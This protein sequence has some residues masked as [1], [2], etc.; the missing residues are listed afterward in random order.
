MNIYNMKIEQFQVNTKF[1]NSLPPELSKF[2]IDVKLV[3]DLHTTNFDQLCAYLEQHE[4]HANEVRLLRERNQDPLAFI[5][6]QQMTPPHFN[7]YQDDPIACLNKAMDFL[8]V[9]ASSRFPSTNNQLRT[10]SN[11]RNHATIQDD[12]DEEQLELLADPGVPDGQAVQTIIPNNVAF[13][14]EDLDTYDSDCDDISNAK[15][16]LIDNISNYGS[17]VISEEKI[18]LKEQVDSL[19]KNLLKQIKEKECLLQTLTAFKSESKEKEDK[20]MENKIDFKKKIKEL[21]NVLF[22]VGQ[23]AQ[24]VHV[25]TKPQ[26]FYDN[27]HKQALGYQN[28]FHLK[29]AQ[30]IKP[31][32]YDGI[33]MSDKHI[34]M[35]VIDDEETLI[36]EEEKNEDLKVQIQDKVFVITSL[37]NDLR[38]IKGKEIADIGA[39]KPSANTIVP[40]MFKLDLEP[41]APCLL[42]NK[43]AHIDYLKL[44]DYQLGNVT[45]SRVY[46][47]EGLGHNLFSIGQFCNADLV[48]AFQKNTCFI[49]NL[50]GVDLIF[51][52]YDINL[53]TIS[54]DD[55]LKTSSICILSKASKTKSW[56]WHHRLSHLN[57]GTLNK[58]AKDGLARGIPRLKFLKD[59]LCS[60]CVLGKSKKSSHQPKAEHI[61]QEKLYLLYMDLCGPMRVASINGKRISHQTSVARTPQQN[62]VV[63]RQNRT[64]VEAAHTI[65]DWDHLFQPM[66]D[67]YFTPPSIVVSP[68]LVVA[69]PRA[70]DLADSLVSTLIDQDAPSASIPSIQKQEHSLRISQ[71]FKETPKTPTFHNDPLNESLHEDSTS[72]GSSLNVLQIQTLFKHLG[73]WIKDH[74][75]AN[76]IGDPSRSVST[77]KQLKTD[78]ILEVWELVQC[79]DKVML[80]KLKWIYKLKTDEFG[81]VLKNKARLVAQ[82]FRQEEGIDFEESFAPVARIEAICIF[83]AN[84]AH[85][86]M[87]SFQ[88]D[89]KTTFLNGEL[90]EEVYVS[91]PEGYVDQDNPSHVDSVD[92]PMVEKSKL[93]EDLQGKPVDTKLYCGMIGSLMY[94]TSSRPD[95]IYAVCLCARYQA[96]PIEK[97]LNAVKRIF[98]YL[99]GTIKMGLWYSKDTS[100]SLTAYADVDHAGCQDTR[101]STSGSAQF[102]SDKLLT[103]YGFQFNKIPLYCDNKSAIAL[104]CNN[105][106]HL[107][108][109]HID[110]RYHFIKEQVKNG[111]VELYFVRTEY[112]LA[113][114][115]TKPLPREKF[116][117]LIEKLEEDVLSFIKELGYSG[118]CEMLSTIRTDQMHQPWRT[119]D[120]AMYNQMNVDYVALLWEDFMYQA[121]N[122]KISSAR[123]EHMP[124]PRFTKVIINHFIFKDNTISMRNRI[125]LYTVR[126][127]TLLAYKTYI[128]YATRKVPPKKA[129]NFKK[130]AS[131]KLKTVP[132]SPKEPTQK[133]TLDKSVSKKKTPAKADSGKGIELLSDA[134]L[135]EDAQLKKTLR[136]SKRETHKL[137]RLSEDERDDVHEED[138]N[139][140]DDGNDDDSGNDD[141]GGNDAQDSERTNSDDDENPSFTLKDYQEEEQDEEYVHTPEKENL[142]MNKICMKKKTMM[143]QRSY[144]QNASHESGFVH[145]EE[146]AHVTLT[147]V[148][149][150]TEGPLQSF[151]VSSDFISKLLNLD[152]PSPD[153]NS[154]MNT[155]TVPPPPSLVNPSPRLT[156]I[157]QQQTPDFTTTTINPTMSL[158]EI[159]NFASL[160]QFDQRVSTLETKVF[161]FNQTSQ[162][163][164]A[165][166]LILGIVDNYLAFKLKEEVNMAVQLQS[167]KLREEDQAENQEFLNQVD[168]TMKAI[169][170]EQV[171]A[172]VSKIIPHIEKNLYNALVESYNTDKHILSSYGDV[173]T[174]KRGR[175]DQDKDIDPSAGLEWGTKRRKSKEPEFEAANTEMQQDQGNES[176]HIDDQPNNEAAPKHDW[177]KKPD[178]P[179]TPDRVW[180]KSKSVDFR[181]PQKWIST[182]AKARQPPRMFDELIGT[183]IDFSAYV[184][185]RLKIDNLT[186]EI[187]V[188]R[189]FNLLKGTCKSFT[190][191]EYH[192]EECYKAV[193]NKLDWNNTKGHAYPFNL[194]KPLPLTED[195]G[196]QV[197]T[198]NYFINN[199]LEYLKEG[200]SSSKYTTST[201]RT[202][203][204]KYDNI[205]GTY[206]WGPKRQRFYAYACHWKSPHDVY[207]KR[208]IIAVTSVKV[209]RW[210]DYR[211]LE[212]IVVQRDDNVRYKFKEGD[213]PRL[214]LCDIEDVL[215][216]LVQKKLS[217]L[218]IDDRYDLGVALRMFTRRII[219]LHRVEDLQIGVESYQKKLNITRP[220][221]FRSDIPNMISYTAYKNPQGIIYQDKF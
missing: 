194:S 151:S 41:L 59:H 56:L 147:T 12:K 137:K 52:S 5:A 206:H 65:D 6:N 171:K 55:M 143:S 207:S 195:Q 193:N 142:R 64:L 95:L 23:S 74:L 38:R 39:Q 71:C 121:D 37:K 67:E 177:F 43:E 184:M 29:K 104:C 178:K 192:F 45:I 140:D 220:E 108:A 35:P 110:V 57:F 22:K 91:Q 146:D 68:V 13:Q 33:V 130:L 120:A 219:I 216:I 54:L 82:G 1:L 166:S 93:D 16:V 60:A 109:K 70:V 113:D 31:T 149:D 78:A 122:K 75:I 199:D 97:H 50:E 118:S 139:D 11:P 136:K 191:L 161:E 132:L 32:L 18:A 145:E 204:A 92:T 176:G 83:V 153:I 21:D 119:F 8:T 157:P 175:D 62:G 148:H 209:M 169:I 180:N 173:V 44:C 94:L 134:A 150:K 197:E 186:Q 105:D 73:R 96:K 164:K 114:I 51:G 25:L 24:M 20:Y 165:V 131:P 90:K 168:S 112:Q 205:E 190:E 53:Y 189:G 208:R 81:E 211:Y 98:L 187:L 127:D 172:Q 174:L 202:K 198:A 48:V 84:A 201:T 27:I 181:P 103:D 160:F 156:T 88:I 155:S 133:D 179:L 47:V 49:R 152:D 167:N 123:K 221:T 159:P 213:F 141:S 87:T 69:A 76:M 3:K 158:P 126:D 14:T 215:L 101:R 124:Y 107:R 182:I 183:T 111:I 117:F 46:Y 30:R 80:I 86:N 217:S 102:L 115:F 7:T 163:A 185:N 85:K 154:L 26:A 99:K 36:L 89:V 203:D 100:M 214:N 10:S 212:E 17:D 2:V 116:N 128:D 106:Q 19:E 196:R 77:R 200:C 28:P 125:N 135:L 34:A 144:Q 138:D 9:V 15:E 63:E 66:F 58:L 129:R 79:Q 61:N 188:G 72:Q 170:K 162:F 40:K 42:Q 218:D 210:Y 4:L